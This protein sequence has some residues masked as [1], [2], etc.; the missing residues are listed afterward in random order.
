M[1]L[2]ELGK[3]LGK[4]ALTEVVSVVK[5]ESLLAWH[6]KLI[7]RIYDGSTHRQYPGRPHINKAIQ[8]LVVQ[9]A[10]EN[11]RWRYDRLV[12]ALKNV[13]YDDIYHQERNHQG[14]SNELLVPLAS[15][16]DLGT[17]SIRTR[18]RLGGLLKYYYRE[19]A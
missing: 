10:K 17:P 6:R 5:P 15:Q 14:K 18:E 2:A 8:D 4:Q 9:F 1:T 16:E 12:G 7:G 13:G 3:R 11:R 19:A